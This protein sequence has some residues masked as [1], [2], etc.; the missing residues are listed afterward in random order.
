MPRSANIEIMVRAVTKAA[1]VLSRDFN[2]VEQ[3]QVSIKGPGD[4]VSAADRRAEQVIREE[5]K[6]GRPDWGFLMEESGSEVGR[7]VNNRWIVDPLDGTTNFLHALPHWAISIGLEQ[8]GEVT[9]GVVFDPLR[10]ELFTAEK[11]TGA[12]LNDRRIRV[13]KRNDM[14]LSL[15][16]CGLPVRDWKGRERGFTKQMERIAD[17]CGGLRRLG[18]CSLDLAYVAAGRQDGFWEYGVHPWDIAA[19]MLMVRE[20]G[21]RVGRLEGDDDMFAE[22]TIVA[23]NPEIYTKLRAALDEVTP[24]PS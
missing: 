17:E 10:N 16:G 19:G 13:S 2:E 9:A 14:K 5:L 6:K 4:Y 1:R 23:G 21:G 24:P 22:G 12:F 20:A 8:H 15:I 7:S 18:V 3:L 11:G